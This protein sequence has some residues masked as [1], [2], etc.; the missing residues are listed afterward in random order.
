MRRRA[1]EKS[2]QRS[3][4]EEIDQLLADLKLKDGERMTFD[5]FREQW[6]KA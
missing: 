1:L 4:A 3:S 6:K 5:E 2:G